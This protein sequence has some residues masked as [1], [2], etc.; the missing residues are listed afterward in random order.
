MTRRLRTDRMAA[1]AREARTTALLRDAYADV[2]A[3]VTSGEW[4]VQRAL[5]ETAP[6]AFTCP[7]DWDDERVAEW[8]ERWDEF[9]RDQPQRQRLITLP[10]RAAIRPG[11]PRKSAP[12][13]LPRMRKHRRE[14][15]IN[16]LRPDG[17]PE[18]AIR[19]QV[20][21]A[22]R[23]LPDDIG[24]TWAGRVTDGLVSAEQMRA[25]FAAD[26][27]A[28][29]EIIAAEPSFN[30]PTGLEFA[31]EADAADTDPNGEPTE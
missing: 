9:M 7:A 2:R 22:Y 10:S 29:A 17:T 1:R 15:L 16:A 5:A 3:K 18:S 6:A 24:L 19:V 20:L 28:D 23:V 25:D 11:L 8:Q 21:K 14:L 27:A 4:S 13:G 30:L 26:M 12:R 31:F